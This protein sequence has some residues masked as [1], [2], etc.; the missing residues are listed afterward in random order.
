[1][2]PG[3]LVVEDDPYVRVVLDELLQDQGLDVWSV[4]DDLSAYQVLGQEADRFS[5][6]LTDINLGAGT[7]GFDVARRARS[8]NA[9]I[10]VIFITGYPVEPGKFAAEGG[11]LMHKPL[12]LPALCDMVNAAAKA[13][14]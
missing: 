1:M 5:V 14:N 10:K 7:T 8:L 11:M 6:L 4:A 3:V 9:G 12:N 13:P 2:A